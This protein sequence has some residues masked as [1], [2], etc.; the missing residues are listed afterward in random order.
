[1]TGPSQRRWGFTVSYYIYT[2]RRSVNLSTILHLL[3]HS[4][5]ALFSRTR[6]SAI[7]PEKLPCSN[8]EERRRTK[9]CGRRR[10]RGLEEEERHLDQVRLHQQI[11]H[12][13]R[14]RGLN[15]PQNGEG[16][17]AARLRVHSN[18]GQRRAGGFRGPR[19]ERFIIPSP[20]IIR[21]PPLCVRRAAARP[22]PQLGATHSMFHRDVRVLFWDQAQLGALQ[23]DLQGQGS[24]S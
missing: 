9:G 11:A 21:C 8:G 3:P 4:A 7:F 10:G 17:A 23:A 18:A 20:P 15:S 19:S 13:A 5:C 22:T 24:A 2:G 12:A 6:S 16:M 1:M 14:A